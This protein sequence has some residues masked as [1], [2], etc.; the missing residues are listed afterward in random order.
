MQIKETKSDYCKSDANKTFI[1]IG[2]IVYKI[3]NKIS[4]IKCIKK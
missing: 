4:D 3:F 1:T 2:A